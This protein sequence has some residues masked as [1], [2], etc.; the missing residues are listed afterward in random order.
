[1]HLF[2]KRCFCREQDVPFRAEA[3]FDEHAVANVFCPRCSDRAPGEALMVAVVGIPGWSGIYGIDWNQDSLREKDPS[4]K[5]TEAYFTR[6]SARGVSFGFLPKGRADAYATALGILDAL[7]TDALP[8][9]RAG[10]VAATEDGSS[11]PARRRATTRGKKP[12]G[13]K[14]R[15][16]NR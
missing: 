3:R 7:P 12:R 10:R 5:D 14:P 11:A 6:L 9:G 16:L 2:T 8:P 4:F 1:M 15:G 13:G